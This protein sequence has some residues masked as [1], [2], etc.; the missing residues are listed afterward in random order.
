MKLKQ[1][2][3]TIINYWYVFI[4]LLYVINFKTLKNFAFNFIFFLA[5]LNEMIKYISKKKDLI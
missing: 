4:F 3:M 5:E 1:F 2:L